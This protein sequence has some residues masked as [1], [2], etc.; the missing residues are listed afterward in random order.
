MVIQEVVLRQLRLPLTKPYRV[1]FRTYTEFEPIVV[2]IRDTDGNTGWGE[3]YIPAGSTAETADGA[4]QFCRDIATR[5]LGMTV[6]E[7][8]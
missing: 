4:W 6:A 3:A 5:L 7:A 1:S 8:K 2:E